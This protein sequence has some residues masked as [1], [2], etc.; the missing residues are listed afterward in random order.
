MKIMTE[1]TNDFV[2]AKEEDLKMR[3]QVKSLEPVT[4]IQI[5]SGGFG[6]EIIPF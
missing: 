3:V 2:L 6:E 4:R 1:T 5:S